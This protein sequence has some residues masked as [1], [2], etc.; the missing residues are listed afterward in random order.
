MAN[1]ETLGPEAQF[2]CT[3]FAKP[4]EFFCKIWRVSRNV[5]RCE[6]EIVGLRYDFCIPVS[7]EHDYVFV[8]LVNVVSITPLT[9]LRSVSYIVLSGLHT[10]DI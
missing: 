5:I 2:T 8:A 7:V 3:D 10:C 9:S 6:N 4:N 1:G